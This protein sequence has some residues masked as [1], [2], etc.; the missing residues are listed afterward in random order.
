MSQTPS[1]KPRNRPEQSRIATGSPRPPQMVESKYVVDSLISVILKKH[2]PISRWC[3]L[4]SQG[5]PGHRLW[6]QN[7]PRLPESYFIMPGNSLHGQGYF[8]MVG[9]SNND[10]LS[11]LRPAHH[12]IMRNFIHSENEFYPTVVKS[13]LRIYSIKLPIFE[14]QQLTDVC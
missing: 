9:D 11:V 10:F 6:T 4:G 8:Q 7:R 14:S 5:C 13:G 3:F 12:I 1:S 2:R